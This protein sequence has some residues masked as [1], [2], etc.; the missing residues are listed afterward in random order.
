[1]SSITRKGDTYHGISVG[2]RGVFKHKYG[3][4]YAGH[5]RDG[6]ACGL[7]VATYSGG[8]KVYA[9]HGPDGQYDGRYL[10]RDADGDTW[11]R[12]YERGNPKANASVSAD[13]TCS[14]ND[15]ACA[16]DDPRLL[17]LIAQVGPVEVRPAAP[18][19]LPLLGPPL[20]PIVRRIG[21]PRFAPRRRS[22]LPWPPRC[23]PTP[24]AVAGRCATQPTS[25]RSATHDHAVTRARTV[26]P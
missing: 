16:P 3:W 5:I 17:A 21:R 15:E 23:I 6:C 9:E 18:A 19:S 4:T 24:H 14:Y 12:L 1:M 8:T 10:L 2:S 13:G 25:S 20:A 7:G 11:Y 26:L 22:R